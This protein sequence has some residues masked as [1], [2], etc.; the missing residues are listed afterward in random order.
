MR[1]AGEELLAAYPKFRSVG[2]PA[3]ATTLPDASVEL[4]TAAQAFHWFDPAAARAEF[5]RIL[6]P[7]GWVAVIWNERKKSLGPFAEEYETLCGLSARITRG[8]PRRI[9]SRSGWRS[10][11]AWGTFGIARFRTSSG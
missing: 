8:F 7:S 4:V 9:R 2:A 6:R 3:E 11:S 10:F 5:A 1:A